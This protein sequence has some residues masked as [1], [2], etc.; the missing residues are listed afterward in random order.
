MAEHTPSIGATSDCVRERQ[1]RDLV[2]DLD[3]ARIALED[4]ALNNSDGS[5]SFSAGE[6]FDLTSILRAAA[7]Y[8]D[9]LREQQNGGRGA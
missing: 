7:D 3:D 9:D 8:L 1:L 2:D 6:V 5:I 4:E